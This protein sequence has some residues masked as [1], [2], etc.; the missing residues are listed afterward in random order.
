MPAWQRV[1]AW[2]GAVPLAGFL[3]VHLLAQA[4][5]LWGQHAY[6]GTVGR[7]PQPWLAVLEVVLV[8][9]PLLLHA[10]LGVRRALRARGPVAG[11]P[12]GE[13]VQWLSAAV[14]LVFLMLHVWQFRVRTWLGVITAADYYPELCASLSSTAWGGVPLV[15]MGYLC[16]V[17]A[18]AVHGANGVYRAALGLGLVGAARQ[19]PWGL[20]CGGLAV[21]LFAVGALIVIDLASGS[22]LIHL[23]G[24]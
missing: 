1:H 4:P 20:C 22:V 2:T 10:G 3:L 5:A 16:G 23:R 9:V 21:A 8:Y 17:T 12:P 19:R 18:A 7:V 6:A 24:L 14:L 15:A 13:L 11:R